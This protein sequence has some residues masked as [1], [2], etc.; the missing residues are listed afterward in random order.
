MKGASTSGNVPPENE[1][2]NNTYPTDT[3]AT[4][5]QV[6]EGNPQDISGV[7]PD[8]VVFF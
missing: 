1:S 3:Q 8:N 4:D 6:V 5:T 7:T 2:D